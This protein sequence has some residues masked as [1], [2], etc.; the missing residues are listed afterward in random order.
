MSK[1]KINE[2]ESLSSNGDLDLTPNGTGVVEIESD[3]T[4][5][6]LQFNS[7]GNT[8]KVKI[9]S[10]PLSA[11]QDYT[12]ILPDNQLAQDK[13]LKVTSIT[14]SG[15]TAVGQL[16]YATVATPNVNLDGS[17]VTTGSLNSARLPSPLS[18]TSG[19]A[20][21]HVST[22][23]VPSSNSGIHEF[24]IMGFEED[25]VYRLITN[26]WHH[27]GNNNDKLAVTF[28][29]QSGTWLNWSISTYYDTVAWFDYLGNPSYYYRNNQQSEA[30]IYSNQHGSNYEE[31]AFIADITT[32][33]AANPEAAGIHF[34]AHQ[35]N[36]YQAWRAYT[37]VVI[38]GQQYAKAIGGLKF[39]NNIGYGF[40]VGSQ[41]SLY[42]YV[43][44]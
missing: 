17:T 28:Y 24:N 37:N 29:D 32:G 43:E 8:S 36:D 3:E 41:M 34:M 5:G 21:K 38:R 44:T 13:Y 25:S 14:G 15:S 19:L 9:T 42:K 7:S 33:S 27:A 40:A 6:T 1:I 30:E 12:L 11:A 31:I 2:I 22:Y 4:D 26:K 16:Q 10:P 35:P 39:K 23:T 18:A 20:F